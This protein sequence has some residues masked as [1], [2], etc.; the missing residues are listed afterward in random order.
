MKKYRVAIIG[1]GRSGRDIHVGLL[2][3]L[4]DLYEIVAIV[5][6]DAG[7]REMIRKET[8]AEVC[9]DYKEL[10]DRTDLDFVINASYSKDHG[11]ISID[12]MEHGFNVLSEKP[13]ANG[14]E[15]FAKILEASEKTGRFYYVFQQ[16]RFSPSFIKIK[17]V[18]ASGVLGRILQITANYDGF[19]RRW[20]WQT[21]QAMQG[22]SL[23]NTGPHPV[24]QTLDLMGFPEGI[25]VRAVFD[26]AHTYGDAEDYVKMLLT[27]PG[28]PVGDV[29]ITSTNAFPHDQYLI[30]GTRGTLHGNTK[31]LE[32]K[33]YVEAEQKSQKL[34]LET[35]RKED[36]AP[37]YCS[38]KLTFHEEEWTAE[39]LEANDG[40][41]KGL[42][43]YRALYDMIDK[44]TPF[45]ITHE[46]IMKQMIVMD[47]AH[48]QNAE[49][50]PRFVEI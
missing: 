45:P 24:D 3:Q 16:Y 15:Q 50:L 5:D 38:E 34:T 6:E 33:Y 17:D 25:E 13:A 30:Q 10:F 8:D 9:A 47:E 48:K 12:L 11:P 46:Q 35:L 49:K 21:V 39:G 18:I 37:M 14:T 27:A 22:G 1:Y 31:H 41:A 42:A 43:F 19:G 40:Q 23:F 4:P 44:G 28:A 2:K 26:R 7:R 29:E 36:G 32:W 20:D